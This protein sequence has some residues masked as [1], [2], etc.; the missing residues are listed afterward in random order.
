MGQYHE[1]KPTH[2]ISL[3]QYLW[4]ESR[5][6]QN[7]PKIYQQPGWMNLKKIISLCLHLSRLGSIGETVQ[8]F[9]GSQKRLQGDMESGRSRL[10]PN[11]LL[12]LALEAPLLPVDRNA[13][14]CGSHE[15]VPLSSPTVR[16]KGH[17]CLVLKFIADFVPK[18]CFPQAGPRYWLCMA[19]VLKMPMS[20]MR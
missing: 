8:A 9:A 1:W 18:L 15:N 6:V 13:S 7:Q 2:S 5:G 10:G 11:S 16:T 3:L 12:L 20:H 19:G 17:S 4:N 14:A